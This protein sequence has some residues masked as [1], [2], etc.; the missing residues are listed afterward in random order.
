MESGQPGGSIGIQVTFLICALIGTLA[1]LG[2]IVAF[3]ISRLS[4]FETKA[5]TLS[6][7][8]KEIRKDVKEVKEDVKSLAEKVSSLDKDVAVTRALTPRR[9]SSP[10]ID[11]DG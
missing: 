10:D 7:G 1:T 5:D 8:H 9:G 3:V 2:G 6:D 4:R 11:K